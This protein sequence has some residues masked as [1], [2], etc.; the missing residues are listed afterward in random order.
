[1]NSR[2]PM[3]DQITGKKYEVTFNNQEE[4]LWEVLDAACDDACPS[5]STKYLCDGEGFTD[6]DESDICAKCYMNWAE[7]AGSPATP[8]AKRIIEA[9]KMADDIDKP[10]CSLLGTEDSLCQAGEDDDTTMC[11]DCLKRWA[12]LPFGKER[13]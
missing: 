3:I 1:M 7:G 2:R 8:F 13:T 5:D 11:P 9:I 12:I 4:Y 10:Q 6:K